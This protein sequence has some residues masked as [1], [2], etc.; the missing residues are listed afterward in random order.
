MSQVPVFNLTANNLGFSSEED[1]Q[2]EATKTGGK[3]FD[4][5]GIKDLTITEAGFHL[6]RT[7]QSMYCKSDPTWFNVKLVLADDA[8]R[9]V[10]HWIQVPTTSMYF[11]EKKTPRV[12]G[13][14]Q[15]FLFGIGE[16]VT[17]NSVQK[18]L[19]KYFADP[20]KLVG[21]KVNVTLGY[22][23]PFVDKR[24]LGFVVVVKGEPLKEDGKDIYLP[25]NASAVQYAKS[26]GIDPSYLRVVKFNPRPKLKAAA[27]W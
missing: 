21:Q 14:F 3:F 19:E 13:K 23:G 2:A 7:T 16:A 12:F 15:E 24:P 6:N 11:G 17:L 18:L 9:C 26:Q 8:G 10:N 20:S 5:P 4:V 27:S 25:D 1:F 22:E